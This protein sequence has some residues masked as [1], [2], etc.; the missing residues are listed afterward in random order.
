M[1][2]DVS[3]ESFFIAAK[4]WPYLGEIRKQAPGF[5]VQI[6]KLVE[7]S[8]T[9]RQKLE[10]MQARVKKRMAAREAPPLPDIQRPD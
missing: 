8:G 1:F 5:M 4:F 3:T 9:A 10:A 2:L 6:E 7:R